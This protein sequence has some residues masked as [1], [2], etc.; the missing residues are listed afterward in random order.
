M[1]MIIEDLFEFFKLSQQK[2][3]KEFIE[4]DLVVRQAFNSLREEIKDKKYDLEIESNLPNCLGDPILLSLV[5][6]NLL[7]NSIK[8]SSKSE[9]P[10]IKIGTLKGKDGSDIY[11]I[12][13]NDVGFDM[14][15]SSKLFNVFQRL[16][17]EYEGTGIGLALVKKIITRHGGRIWAEAVPNHGA[18]FY[19]TV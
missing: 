2:I 14:K 10:N 18:T 8:Y 11:F 13:D 16:H 5:W 17:P 1:S 6:T 4:M 12:K 7:S 15:D 3:Q 9:K 19:F